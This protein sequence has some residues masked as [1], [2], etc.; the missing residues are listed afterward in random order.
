[1]TLKVLS[2]QN[3]PQKERWNLSQQME[4]LYEITKVTAVGPFYS[5]SSDFLFRNAKQNIL[6][7]LSTLNIPLLFIC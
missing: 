6:F 7:C 1:M 4:T 2:S 3:N 5:T